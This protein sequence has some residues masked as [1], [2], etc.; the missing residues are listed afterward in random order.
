MAKKDKTLKLEVDY[1]IEYCILGI[2]SPL[3]D[4]KLVL[5]LN[6]KLGFSF[7]KK[8][9][10]SYSSDDKNQKDDFS[11]YCFERKA[12][13]IDY[14]VL[15]NRSTDS[16]LMPEYKQFDYFFLLKCCDSKREMARVSA[17]IKEIDNVQ[18]VFAVDFKKIKH[19]NHFFSDLE[20]HLMNKRLIED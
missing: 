2:S 3:P 13:E 9:D 11:L 17:K 1:S 20:L 8:N 16:Y 5:N 18:T 7:K 14:Y 15:A 19:I 12:L 4:Y 6:N 10:L